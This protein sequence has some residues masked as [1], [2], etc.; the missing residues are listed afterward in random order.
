MDVGVVG[1]EV[2][3]PLGLAVIGGRAKHILL[4]SMEGHG[5]VSRSNISIPPHPA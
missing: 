1:A 5:S 3:L 4:F 2:L